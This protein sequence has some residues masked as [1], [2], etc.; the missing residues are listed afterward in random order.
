MKRSKHQEETAQELEEVL[1]EGEKKTKR[2]ASVERRRTKKRI[3]RIARYSGFILLL[4]VLFVG[5]LLWVAGEMQ[6]PY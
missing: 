6:S 4:V 2:R 3:D 1:E 5:F